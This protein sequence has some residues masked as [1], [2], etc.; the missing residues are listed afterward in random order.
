MAQQVQFQQSQLL[1][2]RDQCQGHFLILTESREAKGNKQFKSPPF[3]QLIY[4]Q[5][6][7]TCTPYKNLIKT[8]SGQKKNL[9]TNISRPSLNALAYLLRGRALRIVLRINVEEVIRADS[10]FAKGCKKQILSWIHRLK[11]EHIVNRLL[12]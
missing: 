6:N 3:C 11:K 4:Q 12:T 8:H 1:H 5:S 9:V 10:T 2:S 7:R